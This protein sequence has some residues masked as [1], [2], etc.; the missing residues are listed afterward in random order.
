M[1]IRIKVSLICAPLLAS[2]AFAQPAN[3]NCSSAEQIAGYSTF[4]W[5]LTGST[6][7]GLANTLCNAFSRSQIENDVWFCWTAP[8]S[9]P[10]IARTCG[11]TTADTRLAVYDGCG[12]PEGAGI[13][14]CN[15][16]SCSLQSSVSFIAVAGQ[17]YMVRVGLYSALAE[18][19]SASGAVELRSALPDVLNGPVVHPTT[20]VQYY[21]LSSSGAN[22]ARAKAQRLGGDLVTINDADENEFVRA[23]VLRF[24]G[25]DRRGWLGLTDEGHE[26]VFTWYD[27]EPVTYTNWSGGEPNNSGGVENNVE[28]LGNGFWNDNRETPVAVVY[29][30]VEVPPAQPS[31]PGDV[32]GDLD[33]DLTDLANLLVNFGLPSGATRGQGDLDGDSDVDLIDLATLLSN[34]GTVCM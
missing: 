1:S 8:E 28:M 13:L 10:V 14:A 12:C 25:G 2:A 21:L 16:D 15:D 30:L 11:L 22:A 29:G 32:D 19:A 33:V 18:G 6:T 20:G 31:C 5:D 23:S 24:D 3:D 9:G 34:F 4:A 17:S 27:G 26:G 7:D